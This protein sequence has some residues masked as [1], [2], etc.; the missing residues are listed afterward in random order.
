MGVIP[1]KNGPTCKS[2]EKKLDFR[3]SL[4]SIF[5]AEIQYWQSRT[6]KISACGALKAV[7]L[8]IIDTI[9]LY[10]SIFNLARE[11]RRGAHTATANFKIIFP[12]CDGIGQ[13]REKPLRLTQWLLLWWMNSL[14]RR[15]CFCATFIKLLDRVLFK[16]KIKQ[17][18]GH[19]D[20]KIKNEA[21]NNTRKYLSVII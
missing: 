9:L 17:I 3:A 16:T 20:Q 13:F 19:G 15:H 8:I 10:L 18:P 6:V 14:Q 2:L 5:K 7:T 4:F 12:C 11:R 21:Y 1:L